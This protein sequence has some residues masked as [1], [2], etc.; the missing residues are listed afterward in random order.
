MQARGG[1]RKRRPAARLAQIGVDL[2]L[3]RG[4]LRTDRVDV[5]GRREAE[6]AQRRGGEVAGRVGC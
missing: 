1:E 6:R 3:Q 5:G 4:E 2:G